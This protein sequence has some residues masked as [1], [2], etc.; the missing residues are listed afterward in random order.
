MSWLR[1]FGAIVSVG[2]E[3]TGSWGAGLARFLAT[4]E[5]SVI[6]INRPDRQARRRHGKNDTV[7]AIAAAR[8]VLSG[9]ATSI[10]KAAGGN[11]E[12][13]RLLRVAR[14]SAIH[15]RTQA[16]NQF[17]SIVDTAPDDLRSELTALRGRIRFAKAARFHTPTSMSPRAAAK[18]SLCAIARRWIALDAEIHALDLHL[19]RLVEETAPAL[20]A[21]HA[22]GPDTAGAPLVAAGDNPE[23]LRSEATFA[24][25]CGASPIEA[26]SGRTNRH[27]LNRGG[28]R[29]A[30]SA[31]WRIVLVRMNSDDR[32][33]TLC[34]MP[35]KGRALQARDHSLP[36]A[37]RRTRDLP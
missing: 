31:L 3:G 7:D 13:I 5:I 21:R 1:S 30:N 34:R 29:E 19:R 35:N 23:R 4:A 12:C 18:I 25:L 33:R 16:V 24:S 36:E 26:S 15:A 6:E 22:I 8:A 27:R 9:D 11:V 37:L 2:V 17:Q 20:V 32:T 14:R 10:P 28:N